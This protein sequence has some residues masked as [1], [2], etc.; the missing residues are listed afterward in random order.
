MISTN[1]SKDVGWCSVPLQHNCAHME[2]QMAE[3]S[4]TRR[5]TFPCN[6]PGQHS[7]KDIHKYTW[8]SRGRGL[9]SIIDFFVVKRALRAGEIDV[10]VIRGVEVGSDH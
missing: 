10:K 8:E 2:N 3:T 5:G 6:N 1:T 4:G 9:R 7:L